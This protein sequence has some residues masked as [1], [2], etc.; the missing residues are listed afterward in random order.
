MN[1]NKINPPSRVRIRFVDVSTQKI[2]TVEG[3][4]TKSEQSA[5]ASAFGNCGGNSEKRKN[6]LN[7]VGAVSHEIIY[8]R[9][10]NYREGRDMPVPASNF[11]EFLSA[12]DRW[13]EC[14]NIVLMENTRSSPNGQ[15]IHVWEVETTQ[16]L[17]T[18]GSLLGIGE[19]KSAVLTAEDFVRKF[20]KCMHPSVYTFVLDLPRFYLHYENQSWMPA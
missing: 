3:P 19:D 2:S 10:R 13:G 1:Q 8:A 15:R 20:C 7:S 12:F 16:M 4:L 14:L 6:L 5:L 9:C 11:A 18:T 17:Q